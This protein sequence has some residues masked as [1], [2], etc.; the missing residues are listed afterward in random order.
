[1]YKDGLSTAIEEV[2]QN[3]S[4]AI[5]AACELVAAGYF[6]EHELNKC[7]ESISQLSH[8]QE[9]GLAS[10]GNLQ[11]IIDYLLQSNWLSDS[12][13]RDAY[14][15]DE[16]AR[17]GKKTTKT[18]W[19]PETQK[20]EIVEES[21]TYQPPTLL[22]AYRSDFRGL[23]NRVGV[24]PDLLL[25]ADRFVVD[26]RSSPEEVIAFLSNQYGIERR[27]FE[28]DWEGWDDV[29]NF[30]REL[31]EI[32]KDESWMSKNCQPNGANETRANPAFFPKD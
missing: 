5:Q 17:Y 1:M 24:G 16:L 12:S 15:R 32:T 3:H 19:N 26:C 18:K 11:T 2:R 21:Y 14:L 28:S 10:L 25:M 23:F 22:G 27:A 8:D 7:Q 20:M 31:R 9:V 4:V 13:Y 30:Y 6:V 29:K